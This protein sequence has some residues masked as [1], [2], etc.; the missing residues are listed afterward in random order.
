MCETRVRSGARYLAV[1][2]A[3]VG[4]TIAK[5]VFTPCPAGWHHHLGTREAARAGLAA[6]CV[7][8]GIDA[9][10]SVGGGRR[11]C[12]GGGRGAHLTFLLINVFYFILS[13]LRDATP[14]PLGHGLCTATGRGMAAQ[15]AVKSSKMRLQT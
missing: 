7:R 12:G 10:C 6:V 1:G 3:W 8:D 2:N 4:C 15:E 9:I 11:A 5:F 14:A 13:P